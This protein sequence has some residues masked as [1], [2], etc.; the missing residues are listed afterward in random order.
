MSTYN[1]IQGFISMKPAYY[2]FLKTLNLTRNITNKGCSRFDVVI[3]ISKISGDE[4]EDLHLRFLNAFDIRIGNI[5]SV[6]GLQ[7][8]IEDTRS[9]QIEGGFYR[10]NDLEENTFSFYCEEFLIER[11]G[12]IL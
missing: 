3:V 5:D 4:V 10:V 8:D 12:E 1:D 7:I 11:M 2:R 6:S 9:H